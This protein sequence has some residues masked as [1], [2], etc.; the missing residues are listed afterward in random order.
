[1][2]ISFKKYNLHMSLHE[3]CASRFSAL[4]IPSS[5]S[6]KQSCVISSVNSYL[7]Q[8]IMKNLDVP[9]GTLIFNNKLPFSSC[10]SR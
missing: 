5:T 6:S 10:E 1:M 4:L 8:E 3:Y 2:N 7:F 9:I